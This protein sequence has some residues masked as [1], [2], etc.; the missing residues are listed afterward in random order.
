MKGLLHR[1]SDGAFGPRYSAP[2]QDV[3][4]RTG[5]ELLG[6]L[7]RDQASKLFP[8]GRLDVFSMNGCWGFQVDR[9]R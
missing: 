2:S 6:D 1:P 8:Q 7:E 3:L 9:F 5:R 4:G